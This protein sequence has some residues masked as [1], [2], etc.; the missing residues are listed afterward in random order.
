MISCVI[1]LIVCLI[2]KAKMRSV[3]RRFFWAG[4]HLRPQMELEVPEAGDEDEKEDAHQHLQEQDAAAR[5]LVA[6][7]STCMVSQERQF[8]ALGGGGPPVE[9][10]PVPERRGKIR[11]FFVMRTCQGPRGRQKQPGHGR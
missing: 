9:G 2:L 4:G 11:L 5:R 3:R 10:E 1:A 6:F 8:L 7:A